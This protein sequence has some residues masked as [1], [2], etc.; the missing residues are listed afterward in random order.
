MNSGYKKEESIVAYRVVE[1]VSQHGSLIAKAQ[2]KVWRN[3][4]HL[5]GDNP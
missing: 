5:T 4:L 3:I 2:I 1:E